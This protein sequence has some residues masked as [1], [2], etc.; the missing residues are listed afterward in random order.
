MAVEQ[1]NDEGRQIQA[2]Q[3]A[4]AVTDAPCN[5][6]RLTATGVRRQTSERPGAPTV[7]RTA[8]IMQERRWGSMKES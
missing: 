2:H 6:S 1:E 3:G 8:S 5:L 4:R 7:Q